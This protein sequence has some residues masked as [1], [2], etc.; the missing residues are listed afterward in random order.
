MY[1]EY[2]NERMKNSGFQQE[3]E[4]LPVE[5][6]D[7]ARRRTGHSRRPR[8][9]P[10]WKRAL[11]LVLCGALFGGAAG[12]AFYG[13]SAVLGDSASTA[14]NTVQSTSATIT[15]LSTSTA[16]DSSL[17]VSDVAALGL[18][19]VVSVTNVSV[20]EVENYFGMFG[21]NGQGQSQL[22]ETTSCGSGVIIYQSETD[23][24]MVTNYHVVEDATTLSVT[25][26]DDET[27][28]AE[29]CGYDEDVDIAVIS[30]SL[31]ELSSDTLAEISVVAIGDSDELVVG[32]QV[33]AIGNALGYGQSVTTGIVS[34]VDCT[35]SSDSESSENE[36]SQTM[37]YTS[38]ESTVNT[39]IQTDAAIN[40]GNSGGALLNMEGEL[41]GINTAKISST[42]VEG[43]GYAIPISEVLTLIESMIE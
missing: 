2:D 29:L 20:Q 10:W 25:F 8:R 32:E 30:V 9:A 15:T 21:R 31:S 34:A 14:S 24:Y 17:D 36:A 37:N 7:A 39:Y 16:S 28:E 5:T 38:E 19:S 11:S 40:P 27:Y 22:E 6:I 23:L 35:I 13:M 12:G 26:V 41:I 43:M 4:I 33:V 3:N 1:N 18:T 42:D